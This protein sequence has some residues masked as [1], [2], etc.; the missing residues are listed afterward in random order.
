ML[1][2]GTDCYVDH[3]DRQSFLAMSVKVFVMK[4]KHFKN[5]VVSFGRA[6]FFSLTTLSFLFCHPDLCLYI[7][8]LKLIWRNSIPRGSRESTRTCIQ[9]YCACAMITENK[10]S[11][12]HKKKKRDQPGG[13]GPMFNDGPRGQQPPR[14]PPLGG[15]GGIAVKFFS[16]EEYINAAPV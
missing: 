1:S 12:T 7:L 6:R 5:F 11:I 8:E 4:P 15:P 3:R 16:W 9:I 2:T 14:P 13:P 10:R